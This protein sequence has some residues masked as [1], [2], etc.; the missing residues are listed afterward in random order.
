M[1]L[2]DNFEKKFGNS[3][4]QKIKLANYSWFNLGGNAEF[5]FKPK[6]NVQLLEFLDEAKKIDLPTVFSIVF[7]LTPLSKAIDLNFFFH[8]S[9]SV[10]VA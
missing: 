7:K 8:S 4:S 6:D 2:V 3:F 9:N 5:F 10:S 1:N